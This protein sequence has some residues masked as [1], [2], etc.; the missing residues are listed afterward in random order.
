MGSPMMLKLVLRTIGTPVRA[1]K[2]A[3]NLGVGRTTVIIF[4]RLRTEP[5]IYKIF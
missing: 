4:V 2:A 3:I 1:W 5:K